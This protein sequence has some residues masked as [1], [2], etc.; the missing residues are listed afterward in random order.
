MKTGFITL[1]VALLM[2]AQVAVG[3]Q[4]A[5]SDLDKL[6]PSSRV[7]MQGA[8][9]TPMPIGDIVAAL[10]A[11]DPTV[12][13]TFRRDTGRW[14]L[15]S[16]ENSAFFYQERALHGMVNIENWVS[17]STSD[18]QVSDFYL[19]IDVTHIAGPVNS[20]FGVIFRYVDSDNFYLYA[21]SGLGTYS[22]WKMEDNQWQPLIDWTE[23][24]A[25]RTGEAATNHLGLLAEGSR[26]A[27]LVNDVALAEIEDNT[28]AS[29][30]LALAV[31]TFEEVGVEVAFDNLDLWDLKLAVERAPTPTPIPEPL[32]VTVQKIKKANPTWTADFRRDDGRWNTQSDD[33]IARFYEQGAYHISV[34]PE[35]TIAWGRGKVELSDFYLEVETAHVAGP[36][37]N[38]FG[39]LFRYVDGGNFYLFS[40]SSDGYYRLQ[41]LVN[42]EWE[43]IIEWTPS[44]AIETG[45]G[46][47]NR[48]GV[49]A[50]GSRIG[51][52]VNDVVLDEIEDDT[53]TTGNLAL[54]AGTLDEGGVEIAF[55]NLK[56]WEL[57]ARATLTPTP[58]RPRATSIPTPRATRR[59][60]PTPTPVPE[61]LSDFLTALKETTPVLT[62]DFR[63]EDDIWS[64]ESDESAARFLER[65]AYHIR[66]E[67][68]NQ[69]AWT[70]A[71]VEL[72]D[73]YLEVETAHVA[74]SL[75][76]EF[77]VLFRYVDSENFYMF[78][79][80]SDGYY[81][82][83][84]L[85]ND[86]WE[87]IIRWTPSRLI[88][89]G[90]ESVNR[91]GLLAYGTR[92]ILL[93]NG[94]V[95]DEAE[96]DTF[97]SGNIGLVVGAFGESG[98]EIA[99]DNLNVWELS[100]E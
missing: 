24:D 85:V 91:L 84:K 45:E 57:K 52:L 95:L 53:F 20:E 76:N 35:N 16:D 23:S 50:Q 60:T 37:D 82:L 94:E 44:D 22:L 48:L 27:L 11:T 89:T 98:V 42:D 54:A 83:Q 72:S 62:A 81:R 2:A 7:D 51:L 34:Q 80:S 49:L 68:E 71:D 39:V 15:Y 75:D 67:A 8:T 31:G 18:L 77:G 79:I 90:E 64:T 73:F 43:V 6:G 30:N 21:I 32:D 97:I 36:L 46:S 1:T 74:G 55:D 25:I 5:P 38:E 69:I 12:M 41:K 86:E 88:R 47:V 17:W 63:R 29:G 99:F 28:F 61:E 40:I 100:A 78:S 9:P 70:N 26:I 33:E 66:V 13:D 14:N 10:Q 58:T 3:V 56:V 59:P 92:I 93:V 4:A 65:G 19:E 96:D 87:T